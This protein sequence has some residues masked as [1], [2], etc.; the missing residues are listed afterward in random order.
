M[1]ATGIYEILMMVLGVCFL[2]L[3]TPQEGK[4]K[5]PADTVAS[6]LASSPDETDVVLFLSG[7]EAAQGALGLLASL[8]N[9]KAVKENQQFGSELEAAGLIIEAT[10]RDLQG[11]VGLDVTRD[12][13]TVFVSV[14]LAS[15]QSYGI[16]IR[17][18]GNFEGSQIMNL[19]KL[20][21]SSSEPYGRTTLHLLK[22][23]PALGTLAFCLLDGTTLLMGDPDLLKSIVDKKKKSPAASTSTGKLAKRIGKNASAVMYLNIPLW[24]WQELRVDTD[25][26]RFAANMNGLQNALFVRKGK[27]A[28]LEFVTV[29]DN[30]RQ[31][32]TYLVQTLASSVSTI[33]RIV[34][35]AAFGTLAFVPM[36]SDNDLREPVRALLSNEK[37]V[38]ELSVWLKKN[39]GGKATVQSQGDLVRLKL[40]NSGSLGVLLLALFVAIV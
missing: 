34:D 19:L 29:N 28:T 16:F 8:G 3:G 38:M 11:Q 4:L 23:T 18:R 26:S 21:S 40:T 31:T 17:V 22:S 10:T 1:V 36:V 30:T 32:L 7:E 12:V 39:F 5:A 37:A 20:E 24:L 27:A 2:G 6:A 9:L 13:G 15:Q 35:I 14:Q 25:L 33:E